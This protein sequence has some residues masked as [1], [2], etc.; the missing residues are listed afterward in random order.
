MSDNSDRPSFEH[1]PLLPAYAPKHAS[2]AADNLEPVKDQAFLA[3]A[4]EDLE[5]EEELPALV[6]STPAIANPLFSSEETER[7]EEDEILIRPQ[8]PL[9]S[10]FDV[11]IKARL[12]ASIPPSPS[13]SPSPLTPLSLPQPKI[14]SPPLPPSPTH[15]DTIPEADMPLRKR[16]RL[17]FSSPR[18]EIRESLAA[19]AARQPG[20][21]KTTWQFC[22]L[23]WHLPGERHDTSVQGLLLKNWSL[24]TLVMLGALL[25][26]GSESFSIRDYETNR[27]SGS[28]NVNG[29]GSHKSSGG[30]GRTSHTAC[31]CTYKEFLNYQLLNFKG[32]K[33]AVG[34][35]H[36]FEKMEYVFHIS[37]SLFNA[38][39][40]GH[41]AAY[42]M[43]WKTLT[44]MMAKAYCPRREIKKLETEMIPGETDKVERYVGGQP[45]NIQGTMMASKP[46]NTPRSNKVRKELN[47]LEGLILLGL[48]KRESMLEFYLCATSASFTIMGRALLSART[49]K[50]LLIW[51]EI[52]GI[53]MLLIIREPREESIKLL[54]ILN[55]GI[56]GTTRVIDINRCCKNH[57]KRAK[58]SGNNGHKNGK[59]TQK[60]GVNKSQ[61]LMD[62]D[63]RDE[64]YEME[65]KNDQMAV[66]KDW[67]ILSQKKH[68]LKG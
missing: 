7:F 26:I 59:S 42:G 58:K 62:F 1:A 46:K 49:I 29:N 2:P 35:A 11:H 21:H 43:P 38:K 9:P 6:T 19:A 34:L 68:T 14:P 16:A 65:N 44:K 24:H 10:S 57:E 12:S 66:I 36:W 54:C 39:T 61:A 41:D 60:P 22:E 8:N 64:I 13:P 52:V 48:V 40:V 25:Y 37:N 15:R 63:P 23:S 47:G 4:E 5:E 31:V 55:V 30:G 28:G 20:T 67:G 32:T 53:L 3:P 33:G 51:P 17:S 50:E 45:D 27:N 18:F 56:K